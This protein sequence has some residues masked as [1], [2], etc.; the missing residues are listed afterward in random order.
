MLSHLATRWLWYE[1]T[2]RIL[3]C[4]F[5]YNCV[6]HCNTLLFHFPCSTLRGSLK[7]REFVM[8]KQ[9]LHRELYRIYYCYYYYYYYYYYYFYYYYIISTV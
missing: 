2:A 7:H 9:A 1:A 8:L 4:Y 3:T 6:Q 5:R